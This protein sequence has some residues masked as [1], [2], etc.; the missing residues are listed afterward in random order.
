MAFKIS[1]SKV[2]WAQLRSLLAI[3]LVSLALSGCVDDRVGIQFDSP[4]GGSISQHLRLN[5]QMA[6]AQG[7]LTGL[8]RRARA[9]GALVKRGDRASLDLDLP[10]TSAADLEQKFNTLFA[11]DPGNGTA[12][13]FASKLQVTTTNMLLLERRRL[14]YDLD[15]TSLGVQSNEG[16]MLLSPGEGLALNFGVRGPWGASKGRR[17]PGAFSPEA[18]REGGELLWK[19]Q[20]G[21]NNHVEAVLWMP[22]PIGLGALAI[23]GLVI[24]GRYYLAQRG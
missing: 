11:P 24:G 1:A 20:P 22:S 8:E 10:F 14:I 16:N 21:Q 19:L 12:P 13:N 5:N 9:L 7:W 15:L 23:V 18:H 6:S 2:R 17:P 4:Q 3:V